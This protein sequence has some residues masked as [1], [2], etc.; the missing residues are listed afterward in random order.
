MNCSVEN[1]LKL[2]HLKGLCNY[3]Y[4]KERMKNLPICSVDDCDRQSNS[5]GLCMIHYN[6]QR[7]ELAEPCLA[8][9]CDN[10]GVSKGY[11]FKHY[12]RLKRTGTIET[13][14]RKYKDFYITEKGY[15]RIRLD[16]GCTIFEHRYIM[17]QHLGRDLLPHESVH[18]INGDK[19]DN[20]I[21]NLELW[22]THQPRGQRVIDKIAWAKEILALYDT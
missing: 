13:T 15:K 12:S 11:C 7:S 8:D 10:P 17:Q 14:K 9:D 18:H 20:R 21:E 4:S 2:K 3:H 6:K 22:S 19:L 16:A 1:C 5:K